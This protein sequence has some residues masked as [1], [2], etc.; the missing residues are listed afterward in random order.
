M[1]VRRRAGAD[2]GVAFR[3]TT[4]KLRLDAA[5]LDGRLAGARAFHVISSPGRCC[6]LVR[7]IAERRREEG[8]G[9]RAVLVW[10]P[11]PDL[12]VRSE[13]GNLKAALAEVDVLSPNH[14]ELCG[15]F[16]VQ[17]EERGG[18]VSVGNVERCCRELLD[19]GIGMDGRG[20]VVVRAGKDGC[21]VATRQ[22]ARW[23]PAYFG[24]QQDRVID[25]T[26]GGNAFLGGFAVALVRCKDASS[27]QSL[28]DAAMAGS[29]AASY[30]IEQVGM[31]TLEQPGEH[32]MWNGER[33]QDRL[34]RLRERV[35]SADE[36]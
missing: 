5:A 34:Q 11:V 35:K 6:E 12:C 27:L 14:G 28:T 7:G 13:L 1:R 18:E 4:P 16:G 22:G 3:Y 33:V 2:K 15:F 24:E 8:G 20:A 9:A 32:E 26:G 10:E 31:P 25:P 36:F 17:A 21:Y 29:V 23:L 19:S 30:A